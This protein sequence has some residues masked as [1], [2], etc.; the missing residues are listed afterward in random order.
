[1]S[2]AGS[3]LVRLFFSQ[4][5]TPM[6]RI[7]WTKAVSPVV[8]DVNESM[9]G[10]LGIPEHA[11]VSQPIERFFH[12]ED[13]VVSL[14]GTEV[15]HDVLTDVLERQSAG[16]KAA[17][18]EAPRVRE[19]R[20]IRSDNSE[21]W[22]EMTMTVIDSQ[23]EHFQS[24]EVD[25]HSLGPEGTFAILTFNDITSRRAAEADLL[26]QARFDDLTGLLN[27][28]ALVERLEAGIRHLW[29][30]P[31]YVAVMFCDLDGFKHLNDTLG[32]KYGDEMLV[33]VA[34]RFRAI[35]RPQ[36]TV[37][38]IGGDE[39]V[40]VC[41]DIGSP[42]EAE[43]LGDRIRKAMRSPFQIAGRDYGISIS[44]GVTCTTD[45][46]TTAS[47][48]MR[49]ADLA[50][51]KAKDGGRNRVVLYLEEFE[52]QAVAQVEATEELRRAI[53]ENRLEVHFQ[54]IVDVHT[55][56]TVSV[57]ALVRMIGPQGELIAPDQFIP[58]AETSGLVVQLGENVLEQS[59]RQLVT[60]GAKY[61]GLQMNVNVSPR[62]LSNSAFAPKVFE[63]LIAHGL[64]PNQLCIE[65]TEAAAV[66]ATGPT[67]I[68]LRRLRSYGVEVGIDDFGTGYSS[69]TTLKYLQADVLKID[70]TFIEEI[71]E[72]EQDVA[73][74][75][76]VIQIAH[77]LGRTVV[78]E[79]IETEEQAEILKRLGCDFLQGYLFGRPVPAKELESVLDASFSRD[80]RQS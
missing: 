3:A 55:R 75:S 2:G 31:G 23:H 25:G 44:V 15:V 77:D 29:R 27:R 30:T 28:P 36:D 40:L 47:D 26:R 69:L 41:E 4:S 17:N 18:N 76:A 54:P 71:A 11:L 79:G 7:S 51:Y 6:V 5:P 34:E 38:R 66:E 20:L 46:Q 49:R 50:M 45:P 43:E 78:A 74:V 48:L 9:S 37:A 80:D 56:N 57:E 12:E 70:R 58:I 52:T 64:N 53:V 33:S 63:R 22:V 1:M 73:I 72:D 32:H 61:P 21:I 16:A 68:T 35:A 62:Q 14:M 60:W 59:L 65:V 24:I 13:R 39:F 67:L 42:Q 8:L 10:L 19:L